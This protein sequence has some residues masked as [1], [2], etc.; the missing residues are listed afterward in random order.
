MI[1]K[2]IKNKERRQLTAAETTPRS[3]ARSRSSGKNACRGCTRMHRDRLAYIYI[4]IS[5]WLSSSSQRRREAAEDSV[6]SRQK[7]IIALGAFAREILS[8]NSS[9]F[10]A[11]R[12]K[13]RW[14][15]LKRR[16]EDWL[17]R[18]RANDLSRWGKRNKRPFLWLIGV[19]PMIFSGTSLN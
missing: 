15:F 3:S 17:A 6:C 16:A 9:A 18:R 11:A 4:Y 14:L 8:C 10:S 2:R 1:F 5:V 12:R 7:S 19:Y 13:C